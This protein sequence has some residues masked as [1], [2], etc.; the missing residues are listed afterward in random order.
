MAISNPGDAQGHDEHAPTDVMIAGPHAASRT[1]KPYGDGLCLSGGGYR[2]MLF[3]AGALA[4]LNEAG[5]LSKIEVV[6][7][8]SGG[9]IAAAALAKAWPNLEFDSRGVALG[10]DRHVLRPLLTFSQAFVD[11]PAVLSGLL[12][13]T[14]SAARRLAQAYARRLFGETRLKDLKSGPIVIFCA[15][16]LSTGS[17][18]RMSR[19]YVADYRIGVARDADWRLADVVACSSAFPPFLSPLRIDLSPHSWVDESRDGSVGQKVSAGRA[20]ITDGGV[21]DNHG[22]EPVMK[23]CRR[24]FVSDGG[25]PWRQSGSSFWNWFSQLKR[26]LDTTDNQVRSLRR[27]DLITTFEA[28]R[29]AAAGGV[30][31]SRD[32]AFTRGCYWSIAPSAE[33]LAKAQDLA[34]FLDRA[35]RNPADIPTVLHFLGEAETETVVNWGYLVT[36]QALRAHVDPTLACATGLVVDAQMIRPTREARLSRAIMGKLGF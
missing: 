20:V 27:R 36:D 5:M 17:P 32:P 7:A 18:L 35:Q 2:A 21:Y 26:V 24:V 29:A 33:L 30:D 11:A 13:P 8:V 15:S 16:N 34:T 6:G 23:R 10:F 12:S 19:S 14:S 9:S 3:H 1:S 31:V 25:A 4:R 22:V 28:A